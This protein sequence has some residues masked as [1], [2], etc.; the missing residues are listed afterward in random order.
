MPQNNYL[1]MPKI[2]M[3]RGVV[4]RNS[5]NMANDQED[6]ALARDAMTEEKRDEYHNE[7]RERM[8]HQWHDAIICE[9]LAPDKW[10]ALLERKDEEIH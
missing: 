4:Q 1:N 6:R 8:G 2:D 10:T 9:S 3:Q 7:L 5:M